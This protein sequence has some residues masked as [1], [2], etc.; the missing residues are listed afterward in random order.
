MKRKNVGLSA[1]M[2][3]ILNAFVRKPVKARREY[4]DGRGHVLIFNIDHFDQ[5]SF[6]ALVTRCGCGFPCGCG[7]NGWH[8]TPQGIA[9]LASR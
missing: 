3:G 7:G 4:S 8:I 9:A 2:R 6:G 5:R 1:P